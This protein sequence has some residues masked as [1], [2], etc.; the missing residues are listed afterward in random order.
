[1]SD[2]PHD[3]DIDIEVDAIKSTN[4]AATSTRSIAMSTST[5]SA[6]TRAPYRTALRGQ[7]CRC[8]LGLAPRE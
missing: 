7:E 1:M 8:L 6:M 2:K 4:R 3:R 5:E